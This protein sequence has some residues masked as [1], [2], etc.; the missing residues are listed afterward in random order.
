MNHQANEQNRPRLEKGLAKPY[1]MEEC[2]PK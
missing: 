1:L 2:D